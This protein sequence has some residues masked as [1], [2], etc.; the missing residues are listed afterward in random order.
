MKLSTKTWHAPV[1]AYIAEKEYSVTDSEILSAIRW[2]TIG[3]KNMS[4]F[5]KIIFIAD[6]IETRTREISPGG[7]A[8]NFRPLPRPLLC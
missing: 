8:P 7:Q 3:K 5:E 4:D 6:K 1:G 2:H